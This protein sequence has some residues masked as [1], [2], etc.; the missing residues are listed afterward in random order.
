LR[1]FPY[2]L[3]SAV[4]AISALPA[5]A[6]DPAYDVFAISAQNGSGESGA[7]ILT[8]VG[9]KTKIE[10]LVANAPA[11]VPQPTH[12]HIG[13][14]AKL[15]P[16]PTYPLSPAVNGLSVTTLDVPIATLTN[17]TFAV[18][19]HKSAT[20]IPAYVACGDLILPK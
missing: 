9:T 14:C 10:V 18:N 6:A 16:K 5:N 15:D 8:P 2:I 13:P 20:D 11:G 12:V 17:G 4:L 3:A 7:V 1:L 19:V